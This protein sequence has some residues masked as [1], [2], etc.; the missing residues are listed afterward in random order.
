MNAVFSLSLCVYVYRYDDLKNVIHAMKNSQ[1]IKDI[2]KVQSGVCRCCDYVELCD[3]FNS[4]VVLD[5]NFTCAVD[6]SKSFFAGFRIMS[7]YNLHIHI[8][9][10]C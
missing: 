1:K 4:V 3:Y 6:P 2:A 8:H 5:I 9:C 10:T 7:I